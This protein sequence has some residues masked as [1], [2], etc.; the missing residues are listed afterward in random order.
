MS[1][2]RIEIPEQKRIII[3]N[4][5]PC[6]IDI[7]DSHNEKINIKMP[8]KKGDTYQLSNPPDKFVEIA[9]EFGKLPEMNEIEDNLEIRVEC[10]AKSGR[11]IIEF[12][13][14]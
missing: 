12:E 5:S 6:D 13:D 10:D 1:N 2:R 3:T 7:Y 4:D 9:V 11:I 8:I 14:I